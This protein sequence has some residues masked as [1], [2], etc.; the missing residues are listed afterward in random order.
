MLLRKIESS[1]AE[2][3]RAKWR[4]VRLDT[5]ETIPGLILSADCDNGVCK[6]APARAG[7]D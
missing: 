4:V 3:E 5:Y 6:H 7:S 1:L 2:S